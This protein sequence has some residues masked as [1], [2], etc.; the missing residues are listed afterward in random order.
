MKLFILKQ[1][2]NEEAVF[3][4][5]ATYPE[6]L[7]D[8]QLEGEKVDRDYE[9]NLCLPGNGSIKEDFLGGIQPIP[10]ISTKF[11]GII[12]EFEKEN[13]VFKKVY[14][15]PSPSN[16]DTQPFWHLHLINHLD[17]F[18]WSNSD[19]TAVSIDK[20][21]NLHYWNSTNIYNNPFDNLWIER[22]DHLVIKPE[23]VKDRSIF[24][25]KKLGFLI[26]VN[27]KLAH[28]IQKRELSGIKL[29]SIEDYSY[30][31]I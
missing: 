10:I 5:K 25:I 27:E 13:A 30:P 4:N 7:Y 1:K 21:E 12:E 23:A 16:D 8:Y 17:A 19:Y 28:E 18:D 29:I 14:F 11:K 2:P 6:W 15:S 20:K 26:F 24:R 3:I 22:I 31:E 9:I